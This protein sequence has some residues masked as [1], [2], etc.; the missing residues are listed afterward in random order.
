MDGV[1]RRMRVAG[2]QQAGLEM[3]DRTV[4]LLEGHPNGHRAPGFA[5]QCVERAHGQHRRAE[6]GLEHWH[7]LGCDER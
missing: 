7:H 3:K 6:A 4:S 1:A 2:R 5:G